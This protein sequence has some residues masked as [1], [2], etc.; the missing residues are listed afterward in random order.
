[1]DRVTLGD[2]LRTRGDFLGQPRLRLLWMVPLVAFLHPGL[3]IIGALVVITACRLLNR[4]SGGWGWFLA[5]RGTWGDGEATALLRTGIDLHGL[6]PD[7]AVD[8]SL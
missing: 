6:D 4:L 2:N 1:M 8:P 3:Y 5:F 7:R